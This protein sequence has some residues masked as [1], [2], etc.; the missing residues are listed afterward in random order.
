MKKFLVV[1]DT[2]YGNT[3]LVAEK[4]AEG[5]R[6]ANSTEVSVNNVRNLDPKEVSECETLVIGCPTHFGKSTRKINKFIDTLSRGGMKAKYAATFSTYFGQDSGKAVKEM[7]K[8]IG[9]KKPGLN[10][11]SPGLSIDVKGMKG[12]VPAEELRRSLEF[13]KMVASRSL[14]PILEA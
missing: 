2:K 11:I 3:K 6:G 4:I 5:I 13:G 10:I 7:E 8:R 12:P 14:G 1:Y 9:D